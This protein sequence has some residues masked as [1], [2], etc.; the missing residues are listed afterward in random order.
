MIKKESDLVTF[1]ENTP[2]IN[3][4][5]FSMINLPIASLRIV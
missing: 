1:K 5:V 2:Y 3:Q 4:T